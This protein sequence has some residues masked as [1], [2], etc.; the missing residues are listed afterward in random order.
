MEEI[1]DF[2]YS[3]EEITD[4]YIILEKLK[5]LPKCIVLRYVLMVSKRTKLH[6]CC[7]I[8]RVLKNIEVESRRDWL[9]EV[10]TLAKAVDV[11]AELHKACNVVF[12]EN[13]NDD[14]L[15]CVYSKR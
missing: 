12:E 13:S 4:V 9:A 8:R 15:L 3:I 10:K 14:K 6:M 2:R 1:W 7:E 5:D 11:K